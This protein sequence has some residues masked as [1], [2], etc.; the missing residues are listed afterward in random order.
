MS[1][2]VSGLGVWRVARRKA[3]RTSAQDSSRTVS[4]EQAATL[5]PEWGKVEAPYTHANTAVSRLD[6]WMMKTW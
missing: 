2:M 6:G 3:E 1:T 5:A 4:V